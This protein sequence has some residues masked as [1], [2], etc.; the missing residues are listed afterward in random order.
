MS[1]ANLGP[2]RIR[3]PYDICYIAAEE[4]FLVVDD[5]PI[6]HRKEDILLIGSL[7]EGGNRIINGRKL[8]VFHVHSYDVRP[9]A[10]LQTAQILL[11]PQNLRTPHGRQ[12]QS[13]L[14]RHAPVSYTHL[15][16]HETDSY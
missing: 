13:L 16:A 15:R 10:R 5:F 8:A 1:S 6:N 3:L 2:N 4:R 14:G 12:F 11:H 9:L 7:Y